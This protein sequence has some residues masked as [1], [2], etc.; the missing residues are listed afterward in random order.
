MKDY[1]YFLVQCTFNLQFEISVS[2]VLLFLKPPKLQSAGRTLKITDAGLE[3]SG[4]YTCLATN[5]AGEVQQHIQL[6]VHGNLQ[7]YS[8][9]LCLVFLVAS[10]LWI[11]V[12]LLR[13]LLY[14]LNRLS[15][16]MRI[17]CHELMFLC[18]SLFVFARASQNP[19]LWRDHQQDRSVRLS[20]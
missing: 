9:I 10:H 8:H 3:D 4:R 13:L 12:L 16:G 17:S 15:E 20:H 19:F 18:V 14:V 5:A 7:I 6:S 2:L 1:I 11:S